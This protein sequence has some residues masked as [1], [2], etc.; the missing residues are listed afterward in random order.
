MRRRGL[1]RKYGRMGKSARLERVQRAMLRV[2][3]GPAGDREFK[4]LQRLYKRIDG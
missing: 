3:P 4:K 1:R 2:A